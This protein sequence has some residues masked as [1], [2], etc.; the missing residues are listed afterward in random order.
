MSLDIEIFDSQNADEARDKFDE[1]GKWIEQSE[2]FYNLNKWWKNFDQGWNTFKNYFKH[3]VSSSLSEGIDL[4][5]NPKYLIQ[6]CKYLQL[7]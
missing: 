4:F 7:S 2:F 6:S 5:H 3:R 1:L